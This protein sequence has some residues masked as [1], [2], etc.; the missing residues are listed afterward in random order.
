MIYKDDDNATYKH[1][2]YYCDD[3]YHQY[4]RVIIDGEVKKKD[5]RAFMNFYSDAKIR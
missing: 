4:H 2:N 1:S 5:K 3:H